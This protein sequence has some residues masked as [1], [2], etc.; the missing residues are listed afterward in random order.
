M[1]N[2][3]LR[4]YGFAALTTVSVLGVASLSV[5]LL[6]PGYFAFGQDAS[7]SCADMVF[8]STRYSNSD[9]MSASVYTLHGISGTLDSSSKCFGTNGSSLRLGSSSAEGS[10]TFKFSSGVLLKKVKVL[11]YAYSSS[12]AP[13]ISFASSAV[14]AT[15]LAITSATAPDIGD[16]SSDPGYVFSGLDNGNNT[17][18]TSFTVASISARVCLCKIVFTLGGG[19]TPTTSSSSSVASSSAS[20]SSSSSSTTSSSMP[21]SQTG[22]STSNS[23]G[24]YYSG[25]SWTQSGETLRSSLHS[26][27]STGTVAK[28][29][30]YAYTAYETTD[31]DSNGKIIDIYSNYHYDPATQHENGSGVIGLKG[32]KEGDMYNREHTVPQSIF[33]EALPMKSDLHHLYPTDK[34]VNNRRS[35]YPHA[36]VATTKWTSQNGSKLGSS[37]TTANFGL[38]AANVFEPIDEYKGDIARTYFYMATRYSDKC[39]S[40]GSYAVFSD[41]N[42]ASWARSLYLQWSQNDPVSSKEIARNNAIFEIQKNRNPFIDHPEAAQAIWG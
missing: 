32:D 5:S 3:R 6:G 14:S 13:K 21:T 38:S 41:G 12:D 15:S 9:T 24:T 17:L 42:L 20:T 37:D 40:W 1:K 16:S 30:D 18:S 35:N 31:V 2:A 27:I 10:F 33:N 28:S 8:G 11:A 39:S 23:T 4:F 26:L 22:T 25:I 7:I 29:Y 19:S 34:Y 36:V